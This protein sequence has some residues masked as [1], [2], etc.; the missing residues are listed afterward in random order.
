M[1]KNHIKIAWRN[2]KANRLF[3]AINI[4]GLSLGM[5][6]TLVLFLFISHERSFDQ[7]YEGESNVYRVLL[8][9]E[10]EMFSNETWA[11]SP[12][13]LEPALKSDLPN[14]ELAA[15]I[16]K[17]GFGE[18]AFV[19]ADTKNLTE[20]GLYYC[21]AEIF[22]I[23][24]INLIKGEQKD[25]NRPGVVALSES[26]AQRYF[27][28]G[29]ALGK[30]IKIDNR[31]DLEVVAIYNDL[32]KNSSYDFNAIAS[33]ASTV[34]YRNQSWG[35]ASFE[36]LVRFDQTISVSSIEFQIQQIVNN[37]VEKA[38]QWY[39][40]SLQPL[41]KI[42]LYSDGVQNSYAQRI[43]DINEIHNLSFLAI[44]ILFI[45]CVNYMN[46][47]TARSQKRSKEVG[48]N[49]TLGASNRILVAQFYA[50][51]GLVTFISLTIGVLLAVGAIP[52]FNTL[53][54]QDLEQ[55]AIFSFPYLI[56]FSLIW[57]GTTLTA[58]SYPS[59]YLS[60]F[61]PKAALSSANSPG[62]GNAMIRK[63]LVVLQFAA[64]VVLIVGILV[65]YQQIQFIKNQRLGFEP[66]NVVAIST[67]ALH[68][69]SQR[70]ALLEDF[71]ALTSVTAAAMAQGYPGMGVSG[72]LI[73]KN[74]NDTQGKN[75]QTNVADAEI[76][77]V[78]RL[79]LL[80]GTTLPKIKQETDTI[81]ELVLNKKAV[82]YL[83]YTPE[84]AINKQV[85]IN[86]KN[87]IVGVVD[88][89]NYASLHEP[90]GAYAFTN[91]R[92]EP[93][94]HALVRFT[95]PSVNILPE[96]EA[97]LKKVAPESV[98]DYS[99]LD[100][101]IDTLYEREQRT[102]RVGTIFCG[103]AIFVA[104]LGLFGLAAFT[105]EQRKKEIGVRKVLG[106]S[107]LSITQLLS[108]DFLR[109]VGL[110]LVIA[111]PIA[112]WLTSRWLQDFAYRINISWTVFLMA[113][114]VALAIALFTVSFQAIKA[115]I[116]NPVKSL[117]T[118]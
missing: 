30:N 107:V 43:G 55:S 83:G 75:I 82:D 114:I 49:K 10:G 17:S 4:L 3:S 23:L 14:V 111:F 104:C 117:R 22:E 73:Y 58:G 7:F 63:G 37:N 42:H 99:F 69:D 84:E 60:R 118:E 11:N 92:T 87:I 35:N 62:K 79:K 13:A 105:A 24:K 41:E 89:F 20:T 65:V 48:I 50:E 19:T 2:L 71:R 74:E 113:G 68:Q 116:T 115:A 8:H 47:A 9:T 33:F 52:W 46:L 72:N 59:L 77:E 26:T 98:F 51:T 110:S 76:I 91:G 56:A 97:S 109:L 106:A 29:E 93:K 44:L 27:G 31:T 88:D 16:L 102:A 1:F 78:L 86:Q 38:D 21:D 70:T 80:A 32:P 67:A 54:G 64:S 101:T 94:S 5:A 95:G 15:R 103:L 39:S 6:I 36:T 66:E 45:A 96:L 25:L 81:V 85:T 34:F 112:Y 100:Q 90:I 40:F 28:D 61:S 108:N 53:T 57:M 12:A 18:N